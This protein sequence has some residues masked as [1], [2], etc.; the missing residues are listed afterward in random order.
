MSSVAQYQLR[1]LSVETLA[2]LKAQTSAFPGS[3]SLVIANGIL[4]EYVE[5]ATA[6]EMPAADE[7][8]IVELDDS[9]IL[10]R[11]VAIDTYSTKAV[12]GTFKK[13]DWVANPSNECYDYTVVFLNP[14]N[15]FVCKVID[16]HNKEVIL[17]DVTQ[18]KVGEGV[19]G[20]IFSVAD[21]PDCRF[22]GSYFILKDKTL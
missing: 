19:T 5:Y 9:S 8:T 2:D 6:A 13:A 22:D 21:T 3:L 12:E 14:V 11:W 4:Y 15:N 18:T 10:G 1:C 20:V 16:S 7:V 17:Q